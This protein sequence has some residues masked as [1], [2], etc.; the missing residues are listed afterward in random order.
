MQSSSA[1]FRALRKR[2]LSS[3]SAATVATGLSYAS[4]T[5]WQAN[6]REAQHA[7]GS[8]SLPREYDRTALHSY[9]SQRPVT[10]L[11]RL[12]T[13]ASELGPCV[14]MYVWDFKIME[15]DEDTVEQ[16]QQAHA[17]RLKNALTS[18]GPAFVKAGQQLS[19]RYVD[20]IGQ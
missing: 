9:W 17:V 19:I 7:D 10:V 14:G 5:E 1:V 4:Y 13:V 11:K 18:L 6:R 2:P 3:L 12:V 16:L 20:V 15:E 8:L